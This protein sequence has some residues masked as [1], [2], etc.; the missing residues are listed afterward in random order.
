MNGSVA[1]DLAGARAPRRRPARPTTRRC[2][3]GGCGS[4]RSPS[5]AARPS[6]SVS[7]VTPSATHSVTL[8]S[9][10]V[11]P[12]VRDH[13]A[14]VVG[15]D[16]LD[17]GSS[18]SCASGCPLRTGRCSRCPRRRASAA[19][20]PTRCSPRR[21]RTSRMARILSPWNFSG[22]WHCSQV[23]RAGR[24][25][26]TGDGIGRECVLKVT[27][28]TCR[29]PD[30]FDLHE[31]RRARADVALHARRRASAGRPGTPANSGS[32]TSWHSCPQNCGESMYSM[33]AIGRQ[34]RR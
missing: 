27:A 21:R 2:G 4:P 13:L 14:L 33:P 31:P 29:S 20:S 23:S 32:I 7:A 12:H 10:S 24:R 22:Q 16:V 8:P 3:S 1:V 25:S 5:A 18:G 28:Y 34:R 15:R 17:A 30:S 11:E 19:S 26:C 6:A 9:A